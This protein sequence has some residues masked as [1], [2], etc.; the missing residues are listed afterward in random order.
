MRGECLLGGVMHL[1][2]NYV[3]PPDVT[4]LLWQVLATE[5]SVTSLGRTAS[6]VGDAAVGLTVTSA[7][8]EQWIILIDPANGRYVGSELILVE[9]SESVGFDPP[10]VL[11]LTNVRSA[12]RIPLAD[13]PDE[14][15]AT[16]Y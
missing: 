6:R 16:R 10:A 14:S 12:Q 15:T 7:D 9:P 2:E 8:A 13:V 3:V 11:A 5:P 4:S 1:F